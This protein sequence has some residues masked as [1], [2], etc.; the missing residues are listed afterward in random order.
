M[1]IAFVAEKNSQAT[2]SKH[3]RPAATRKRAH[4]GTLPLAISTGTNNGKGLQYSTWRKENDR[5]SG[6]C[7]AFTSAGTEFCRQT[8]HQDC[9]G[10]FP[11]QVCLLSL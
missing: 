5:K 10:E 6:S 11:S 3:V 7:V 4:I 9:R 8:D 2:P 1:T